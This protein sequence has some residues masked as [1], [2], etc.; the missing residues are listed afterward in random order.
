MSETLTRSYQGWKR[1]SYTTT[2]DRG[3][4]EKLHKSII[5]LCGGFN[6][7][8][9]YFVHSFLLSLGDTHGMERDFNLRKE[10]KGIPTTK[11]SQAVH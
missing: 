8:C 11:G 3:H 7:R 9:L 4:S 2:A 5:Y 1:S 6:T 10:E